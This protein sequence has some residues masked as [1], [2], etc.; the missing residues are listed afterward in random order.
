MPAASIPIVGQPLPR[1]SE[2]Y[3]KP[4]KWDGWTL[5]RRGHGREW[6]Y[7]FQV[8]AADADLVWRALAEAV[9]D[10]PIASVR[11]VGEGLGCQVDVVIT[12]KARTSSVRS[13]WHYDTTS[14]RP[15]L[16]TAFPTP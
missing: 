15:R 16:V 2:A 9:L 4:E 8:G 1:A 6:A 5:A 7:V 11:E 10:A 14:D 13:V 3:V 12:I